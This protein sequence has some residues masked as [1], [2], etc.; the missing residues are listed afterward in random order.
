MYRSSGMESHL[1]RSLVDMIDMLRGLRGNGRA[2]EI[3]G[4]CWHKSKVLVTRQSRLSLGV[5]DNPG[6]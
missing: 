5:K 4:D 2:G 6:C 1:N 3:D